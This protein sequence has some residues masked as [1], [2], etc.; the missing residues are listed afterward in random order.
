M[1]YG[2]FHIPLKNHEDFQLLDGKRKTNKACTKNVAID[3]P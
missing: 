2:E 1:K 3:S